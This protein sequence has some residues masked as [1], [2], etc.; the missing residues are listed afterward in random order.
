MAEFRRVE[1]DQ[2][3]EAVVDAATTPLASTRGF[4]SAG[5]INSAGKAILSA[6]ILSILVHAAV[7][8]VMLILVFPYAPG[9]LSLFPRTRAELVGE[10][11]DPRESEWLSAERNP[12]QLSMEETARHDPFDLR[13]EPRPPSDW[14][15]PKAFGTSASTRQSDLTIVGIGT[16]GSDLSRFG[17]TG[18]G[19][20]A[21]FF[22]LGRS[23]PGVRRIV[24]VVDRSGS[25]TDTFEFVRREMKRSIGALRRSQRFHAIFFSSGDFL[26]NPPRDLVAAIPANKIQTFAFIDGVMPGGG[27]DPEPAMRRAFA[28]NPDVIYFLTDGEFR[29]TLVARLQEWNRNERVRIFTIAFLGSGGIPLLEQIAREHNG[30]FRLVTENDL[31]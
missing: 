9:A 8:L 11:F 28:V 12:A 31:P 30:E 20:G 5:W 15:D 6:W 22:G 27:T 13:L 4:P 26:E 10:V 17:L 23:A 3:P 21:E 19:G 1:T 2:E 25:M 24:Y 16:G 14:S 7:F 29:P 18:G